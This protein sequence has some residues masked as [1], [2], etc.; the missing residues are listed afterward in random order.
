M[1]R[2]KPGSIRSLD[3]PTDHS[4][5]DFITLRHARVYSEQPGFRS[6]TIVAVTTLLDPVE[7]PKEDLAD[8]YRERWNNELDAFKVHSSVYPIFNSICYRSEESHR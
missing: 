5:P 4:L 7:Y 6:K 1:T 8:L 3:W 2:R